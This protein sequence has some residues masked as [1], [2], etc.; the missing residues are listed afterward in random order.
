MSCEGNRGKFIAHVTQSNTGVASAFGGEEHAQV[1]MERVFQAGRAR[2]PEEKDKHSDAQAA[3]LTQRCFTQIKQAGLKPPT[4]SPSGLPK[5]NAQ[6]G[7]AAVQQTLDAI[8]KKQPL[9]DL[10]Q[11]VRDRLHKQ[12]GRRLITGTPAPVNGGKANASAK[13]KQKP[14]RCRQCGRFTSPQRSH[15]CPSSATAQS[16]QRSLARRLKVPTSQFDR[17]KLDAVIKEAREHGDALMSHSLTGEKVRVSLDGMAIAL[18]SGYTPDAWKEAGKEQH[19]HPVTG[20]PVNAQ[21][22]GQPAM[23]LANTAYGHQP[24]PKQSV[25][26]SAES[27]A[28]PVHEITAGSSTVTIDTSSGT[29]YDTGRFIGTEYRKVNGAYGQQ[30]TAKGHTYTIGHRSHSK[31]DWATA[32]HEGVEGPPKTSSRGKRPS[33]AVGSVGVGR[34]LVGAVGILSSGKVA[35]N[36]NG[37]VEVYDHNSELVSAYDPK[38]RTAGDFD[39][40]PNASSK[41]MA[42]VLAHH[43]INPQNDF[44]RAFVKDM[45]KVNDDSGTPLAA[46][47]GAYLVLR[48]NYFD[49]GNKLTM[50]AG[51]SASQCPKCGKLMGAAGCS[52]T[53][54]IQPEPEKAPPAAA[55]APEPPAPPAAAAAPEPPAPPPPPPNV[56][57]NV[58]SGVMQP[59]ADAFREGMKD[60]QVQPQVTVEAPQVNTQV[61]AKIDPN[62]MTKA[63]AGQMTDLKDAVREMSKAV[64]RMAKQQPAAPAS[65]AMI[66][67]RAINAMDNL[68]GALNARAHDEPLPAVVPLAAPAEPKHEEP[69]HE[70]PKH[71]E[72]NVDAAP[73]EVTTQT[74]EVPP[75]DQMTPQEHILKAVRLPAADRFLSNVPPEM[76][77]HRTTPLPES[78]P[79]VDPRYSVNEQSEKTL[80]AMSSMLQLA[81][82]SPER[83]RQLRS[84]GIYGPPGTGKNTLAR[85][86]AASIQT[87]DK[88]GNVRQGM[89]YTEAN[90]TEETS[91]NELIGTT[92]LESDGKGGTRSVATLGKLGTAAASGSVVCINEVV[93]NPKL[94]TKLQPMLEDGYIEVDS[95]EAGTVHVPVHPSTVFVMTWNPG[96]EGDQDRPSSAPLSRI[97]PFKLDAPSEK[98]RIGRLDSFFDSFSDKK[99]D[100]SDDEQ[101]RQEQVQRHADILARDYQVPDDFKPSNEEVTATIRFTQDVKT[102]VTKG[103]VGGTS[104]SPSFP[105]D[106]EAARFA[107]LGK[108]IGWD[109]ALETMKVYCDQNE[110]DYND[111]WDLIKDAYNRH[112]GDAIDETGRSLKPKP[113]MA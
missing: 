77:G 7:Y 56:T 11:N 58:D 18:S 102:L 49:Q 87:V 83:S 13:P 66:D 48:N 104:R 93:R 97:T 75:D 71:E 109:D 92:T 24:P 82:R 41:Q 76:G 27:P 2:A 47:D 57:V 90:I 26:T 52:C 111:Q 14:Q 100:A 105:G 33:N 32:R 86:L 43:L 54:T 61:E 35:T 1:A 99:D 6:Y 89:N 67:E 64:E 65:P 37:V 25:T 60:V 55:A 103:E 73:V 20:Q 96:L 53:P 74:R 50:G 72:P 63:M 4:H 44:D 110:E 79:N 34:T 59:V 40:T 108:T 112:F 107:L 23:A 68:A 94:L 84:F 39:G 88:D 15:T 69:K 28:A 8:E 80:K 31:D 51:V 78:I 38:T 95:P 29:E 70:E 98:E 45:Q 5:R 3:A 22:A 113:A 12:Q 81:G 21:Q 91:I 101:Q 62:E 46:A 106:R 10:A 30:V 42:A 85:Q 19:A 16:L 36:V 17:G 9:P